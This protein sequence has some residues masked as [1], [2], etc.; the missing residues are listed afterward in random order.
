MPFMMIAFR[1][2]EFV[3][4]AKTTYIVIADYNPVRRILTD[5]RSWPKEIEP[6]YQG[7]SIGQ[8]IDEDGDGKY[9]VLE[10]ETRGFKGPRVYD[11]TGLPLHH[12]S[13]SVFKKRIFL[14]NRDQNLLYD[15]IT[16]IDNALTRPWVVTKRYVRNLDLGAAW[17]ESSCSE[18]NA[19]VFV[20]KEYYFVSAD[21]LLMPARHR[22][23]NIGP[24]IRG[25]E[26]AF[27]AGSNFRHGCCAARFETAAAASHARL[28]DR[29]SDDSRQFS[30]AW[31][32]VRAEAC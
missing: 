1:P 23:R 12:D 17:P 16:V 29:S 32:R 19:Y 25:F 13:Q 28:D 6:T 9:D 24:S 11:L 31:S 7:Y 8:W 18:N 14:D 5:G 22:D 10:V 2:L 20:G 15:E 4:T 27:N 30:R 3:I 26:R 21:G